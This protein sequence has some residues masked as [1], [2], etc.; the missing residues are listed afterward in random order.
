MENILATKRGA[1]WSPFLFKDPLKAQ[2][3]QMQLIICW[4]Y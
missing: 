4:K 1:R 3:N 2:E